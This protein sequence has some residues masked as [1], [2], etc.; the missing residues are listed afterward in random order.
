[1]P[2]STTLPSAADGTQS[3]MRT[4][5]VSGG[6]GGIG[7]GICRQLSADGFAVVVADADGEAAEELASRLTSPAGA[8]HQAFSGDL[9]D[10]SVN[11][12]LASLAAQ[13]APIGLIVNAV[14]ISPKKDG[15]KIR[16]YDMDDALWNRIMDVNLT[17]PFFLIREAFRHMP[18]DGTASIVNL[19]SITA[20]TGTGGPADAHFS[21]YIP[22]A[23]AYGASKAALHN[24]TVSLAHEMA[25]FNIRVNGVAPGYVKT[26]M[27]GAVPVD[28]RLLASVPMNRF[29]TPEEIADSVSFLASSKASYITGASLDVN[30]GWATC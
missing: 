17:A 26:P 11:R 20:K 7:Q 2:K 13:T 4:A 25:E 23:V 19:L 15:Q 27:M 24:L 29:A 9:T 21:P 12:D 28:E 10:S 18:R 14:G 1:M 6:A 30:G 3:V 16:F 5:I 8:E 22:S